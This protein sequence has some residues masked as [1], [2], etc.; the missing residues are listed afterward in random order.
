LLSESPLAEFQK[1]ELGGKIQGNWEVTTGNINIDYLD[2]LS[3]VG[4]SFSGTITTG[5]FNPTN[6]GGFE[7]IGTT[8][9]RSLDYG[10][11]NYTYILDLTTTTGNINIDGQSS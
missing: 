11:A 10:S 1:V 8:A 4:A 3:T 7:V 9:F 5:N 6:S 2:T